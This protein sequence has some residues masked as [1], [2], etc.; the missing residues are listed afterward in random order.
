M[1]PMLLLLAG[2]LRVEGQSLPQTT[3]ASSRFIGY[4]VAPDSLEPLL[5]GTSWTTS[6]TIAGDCKVSGN[7]PLTTECVDG[8]AFLNNGATAVCAGGATCADMTIFATSPNIL[9]S[10]HNIA[11]RLAWSANTVYRNLAVT[12]SSSRIVTSSTSSPT[13]TAS[14]STSSSTSTISSVSVSATP[15]STSP[16]APTSQSKAWIAGAVIG[17]IIGIVL[18]VG[19]IFWW[20]RKNKS[21][22]DE[23]QGFEQG[24]GYSS[25]Y[26][27]AQQQPLMGKAELSNQYQVSEL[28]G[29]HPPSELST[30][31][32]F[33]ELS[34]ERH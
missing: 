9:P 34:T 19:A 23:M 11:C 6:G 32:H 33:I 10:A 8:T 15:T 18:I 14:A 16:A 25:D 2:A 5:A 13:P 12:T 27:A 30:R 17:P 28:S 29:H 21:N 24:H 20:R 31:P 1:L 22:G 4:Y 3:W 7:C 26:T